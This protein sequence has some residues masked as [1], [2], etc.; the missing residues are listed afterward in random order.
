M[1]YNKMKFDRVKPFVG[2]LFI[3]TAYAGMDVLS[4][5]A[6][7]E[8]MSVYVYVFYCNAVAFIVTLPFA[9]FVEKY[10]YMFLGLRSFVSKWC[11]LFCD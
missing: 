3:Q 7:N 5:V 11:L 10:V 1:G 4:K 2:V 8:G 9:I 6:L